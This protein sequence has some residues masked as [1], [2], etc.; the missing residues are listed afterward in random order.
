MSSLP[1]AAD[2]PATPPGAAGATTP[3]FSPL[4]QQIK[5]LILQSLQQGEWKPGEAIPSEMELAA[6][7]RVSQGTVRK[8]IDELAA[9]NLVMRRQGK[10]TF[11]ATHAEQH[12]QYR[13]LKLLPDTGDAR[14]EGPAQRRVIDCRRVRA[15]AD[16]AR[17]LALRSGDAVMQARR[18]L[19]FAGVPTILE[20]IWLPGQAFKGLTAEQLANYQ[21][22]T[23]AMFELDFGVRM[24]RAEEKIRAVLP[25]AEQAQLLQITPATP[26]LS[27]ERIAYTYNDVPMELRRG[28]YLTDTHHYR[29]ELS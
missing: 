12:V 15:S 22:P 29:N 10:G 7:F 23:Y 4:Y 25:E 17:T 26:L 14:V 9:E 11:V 18:I 27:V 6:R 1:F 24:V 19:S 20:D 3:A 13:F 16:V 21:G 5:G 8:A 2:T 28:L